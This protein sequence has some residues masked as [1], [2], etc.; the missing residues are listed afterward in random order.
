MFKITSVSVQRAIPTA[1]CF[2]VFMAFFRRSNR[3]APEIG[4]SSAESVDLDVEKLSTADEQFFLVMDDLLGEISSLSDESDI[5]EVEETPFPDEVAVAM[6]R[7]CGLLSMC[8]ISGVEEVSSDDDELV[9]VDRL[10]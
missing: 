6:R 10:S 1:S 8:D 5:S 2:S 7:S 4:F 9:V 3:V